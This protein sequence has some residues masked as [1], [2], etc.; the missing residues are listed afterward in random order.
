MNVIN[1]NLFPPYTSEISWKLQVSQFLYIIVQTYFYIICLHFQ[2]F[3]LV[4]NNKQ[5]NKIFSNIILFRSDG[6]W[7]W[8]HSARVYVTTNAPFLRSRRNTCYQAALKP[9]KMLSITPN[10]K[11]LLSRLYQQAGYLIF[12]QKKGNHLLLGRMRRIGPKSS[13]AVNPLC[14]RCVPLNCTLPALYWILNRR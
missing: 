6:P 13:L 4:L 9:Y 14:T 7:N 2:K 1:A 10:Q 3:D 8:F 5:S 12:T 11:V